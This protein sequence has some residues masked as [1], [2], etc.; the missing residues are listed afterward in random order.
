AIELA[1][2]FDGSVDLAVVLDELLDELVHRHQLLGVA[3]RQ[4]GRHREDVMARLG[5]RF[6][7]SRQQKL[8]ALRRNE[9]DLYLDL[10]LV[11]P[12]LDQGLG[13]AVGAGYPVI[14]ES[15]GK[16]SG[17]IGAADK[18][19]GD[20]RRRR[21]R[22]AGHKPTTTYPAGYHSIPPVYHLL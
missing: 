16:L 19:S 17:R 5:L 4:E 7:R 3:S 11:G 15:D 22:G 14:P 12:F 2:I 10:L 1:E 8:V 9:V 13:G 6:G 18:G 20:E 21:G